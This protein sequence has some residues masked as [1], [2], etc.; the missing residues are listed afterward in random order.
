MS[1]LRTITAF[2][3]KLS[4]GGARPNLFEVQ[5][6]KLPTGITWDAEVF[7][8]MFG[9]EDNTTFRLI[10]GINK[11]GAKVQ[12]AYQEG[13]TAAKLFF[14]MKIGKPNKEHSIVMLEVRYKGALTAE[15]QFQVFMSMK[16]NG[17]K[18]VYDK[19]AKKMAKGPRW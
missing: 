18:D 1:T 7:R 4:G 5:L 10:P 15:P 13:A 9:D 12:Q 17:F 6:A 14:E 8:Y 16:Q 19:M 11:K 3:S 2:K